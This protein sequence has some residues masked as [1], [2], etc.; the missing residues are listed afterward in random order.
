MRRAFKALFYKTRY[1]RR[2]NGRAK[3]RQFLSSI[4]FRAAYVDNQARHWYMV[5]EAACLM[6]AVV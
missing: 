4:N 3:E 1:G 2:R 5:A 6:G